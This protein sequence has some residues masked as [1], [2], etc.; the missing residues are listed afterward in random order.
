MA[1]KHINKQ[2]QNQNGKTTTWEEKKDKME[3]LQHG[4]HHSM[5]KT[6]KLEKTAKKNTTHG[7]ATK[8]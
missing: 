2:K 7:K 3:K 5:E 6:T 4:K 8:L 1:I